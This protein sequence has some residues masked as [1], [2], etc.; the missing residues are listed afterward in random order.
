MNKIDL[1]CDRCGAEM[2]LN[3]NNMMAKCPYCKNKTLYKKE[4]DINTLKKH[5]AELGYVKEAGKQRAIEEAENKKK[6]EKLKKKIKITSIEK[7]MMMTLS[8]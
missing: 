1:K 2:E 3:E 6:K 4:E 5:A 7:K 8:E